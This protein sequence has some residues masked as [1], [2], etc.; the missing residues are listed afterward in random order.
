MTRAEGRKFAWTLTLGFAVLAA[1]AMWRHRRTTAGV[2][3]GLALLTFLAGALVP[4]RLGPVERAWQRFGEAL[5]RVTS[6]IVFTILYY[7]VL[8]PMG[9]LRRT[10]GR[11]PLARSPDAA[12]FWSPRKSATPEEARRGMEHLF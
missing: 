8:T 12:T 7:V 3:A 6:P 10:F 4:T 5:S 11:S 1:L 2:L 9:I